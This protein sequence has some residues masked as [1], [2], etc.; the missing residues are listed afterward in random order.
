MGVLVCVTKLAG[1][2]LSPLL[3]Y[4]DMIRGLY[5]AALLAFNALIFI[6]IKRVEPQN[7]NINER[8]ITK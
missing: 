2:P 3:R 5:F 1:S 6:L 8:Y 7:I 4:R